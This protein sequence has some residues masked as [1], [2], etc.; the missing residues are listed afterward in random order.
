[1]ALPTLD[2]TWEHKVNIAALGSA[3]TVNNHQHYLWTVKEALINGAGASG[4]FTSPWTVRSSCDSVNVNN[5]DGVDRWVAYSNAVFSD[6]G[7]HGWIVLQ[8]A[9]INPKFQICIDCNRNAAQ[10]DFSFVVSPAAGFGAA[11]GGTD[12]TT[13]ARPTATD[14]ITLVNNGPSGVQYSSWTGHYHV[15]MSDDGE[16]TRVILERTHYITAFWMFD[17]PKSPIAPWVNSAAAC[18]LGGSG[19]DNLTGYGQFNDNASV[20]GRIDGAYCSFYCTSEMYISGMVG[21]NITVPDDQTGEWSMAPMGLACSTT[22]HRGV[23]KGTLY[24]LWWASDGLGT[25]TTYP[26]DGS[27]QFAQFV[28]MIFPWNGTTPQV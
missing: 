18:F 22:G 24:D 15:M 20:K 1:M 12:G 9:A 10:R 13:T 6:S 8:N 2:K 26:G 28:D 27:R 11:N 19:N 23:R 21:Q 14:Q 4:S 25:G 16:C 3:T 5:N 7:A 17:K